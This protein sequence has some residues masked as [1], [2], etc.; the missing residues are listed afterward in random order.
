MQIYVFS[1]NQPN[2]RL[3]KCQEIVTFCPSVVA[4]FATNLYFGQNKPVF[5]D[6]PMSLITNDIGKEGGIRSRQMPPFNI[7]SDT[8]A[9]RKCPLRGR[10]MWHLCP[11]D[12]TQ[13]M[14]NGYFRPEKPDLSEISGHS[15]SPRH[16][17]SRFLARGVLSSFFMA[18]TTKNPTRVGSLEYFA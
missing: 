14:L 18:F 15:V 12:A 10:R 2:K 9:P 6:F 3:Q 16:S 7:F 13:K 17:I 4:L 8:F 5:R 11:A 1:C